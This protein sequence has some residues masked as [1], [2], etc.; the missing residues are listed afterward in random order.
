M[1][2]RILTLLRYDWLLNKRK[3][4]TILGMYLIVYICLTL[5]YF[6]IK[7]NVSSS[8]KL[9][10]IMQNFIHSYFNVLL[11][12]TGLYVTT[13]LHQ[14]F[15]NPQSSTTYLA[16][17][18]TS[19]EKFIVLLADY[20]VAI[21]AVWAM[22]VIMFVASMAVFKFNEPS[23]DWCLNPFFFLKSNMSA[24]LDV[25]IGNQSATLANSLSGLISASLYMS[26]FTSLLSLSYYMVLNMCFRTN[27]QV[28]SIALY[29][30]TI[31]LLVI[32][33]ISVVLSFASKLHYD[34]DEQLPE[35][36]CTFL[37]VIKYITYAV[38]LY[39]AITLAILHTQIRF[40]Q[41]K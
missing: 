2:K 15:T 24:D 23:Y 8:P 30:G 35:Q 9:P 26:F 34:A 11:I 12:I 31:V 7:G 14:K 21:A 4:L 13:L 19:T 22:Y 1:T 36:F 3:A 16:L 27:G 38:P 28:K 40:K 41:A 5:F 25:A 33:S 10:F 18:G 32:L 37:D 6:Y 29:F 39:C 20:A 17:P